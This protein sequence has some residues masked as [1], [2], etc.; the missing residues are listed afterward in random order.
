MFRLNVD[1]SI[2]LVEK[3]TPAKFIKKGKT[4]KRS[5]GLF[6]P[7]NIFFRNEEKFKNKTNLKNKLKEETSDF[8][9]ESS[10]SETENENKYEYKNNNE[11]INYNENE[12]ESRSEDSDNESDV[13]SGSSTDEVRTCLSY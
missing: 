3:D 4:S 1:N 11:N 12:N 6:E 13:F 9:S 2:F 10:G 8:F 7:E 5:F